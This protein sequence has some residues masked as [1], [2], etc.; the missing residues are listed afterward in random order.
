MSASH[1]VW[2]GVRLVDMLNQIVNHEATSFPGIYGATVVSSFAE[3]YPD[4]YHNY[5]CKSTNNDVLLAL[6]PDVEPVVRAIGPSNLDK[7]IWYGTN[8]DPIVAI[9]P[10]QASALILGKRKRESSASEQSAKGASAAAAGSSVV[11]A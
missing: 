10:T 5:F 9:T 6:H 3:M 7:Y 4:P 11:D 2:A 8:Q 1:P